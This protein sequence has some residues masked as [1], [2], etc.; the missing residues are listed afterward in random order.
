M[1]VKWTGK[2]DDEKG[3]YFAV[4]NMAPAAVLY[5]KVVVYFYD[6]DGKQLEVKDP[7]AP[8]PSP[9]VICAGSQLF[10]GIMKVD[11][12]ATLTF[13]CVKKDQIPEGTKAIEAEI[14]TV[15]FA[16][17]GGTKNEF[18]W[19]NKDLYPDARPKGGVK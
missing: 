17:A 12:K 3:P 10:S 1:D 5:G 14:V 6:K 16:D 2:T 18:Y 9:F 4:K 8:K 19:T 11:E 15:G 13:S 7:A